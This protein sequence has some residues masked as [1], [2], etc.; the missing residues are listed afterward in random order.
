MTEE[1][2]PV[3][4]IVEP[5]E[6]KEE[7]QFTE[8]EQRAL[9]MGWKP[10]ESF[11]GE[12]DDFID[13]KEFVRRKP[14]FDKIENQNRQVKLLNRAIN[15]L[16]EHYTKVNQASYERALADLKTQRKEAI[17]NGDGEAFGEIDDKIK[18]AEAQKAEL[19]QL[20]QP[21]PEAQDA[22]EFASWKARNTWYANIKYMRA[23]ADELG[24]D[25]HRRGLSPQDVLSEVEKAV[26]NE[27]PD[28]F[29]NPNKASAVSVENSRNVSTKTKDTFELTE[30]ERKIMND[31]VRTK[32]MTKEEYIQGL[33]DV[34]GL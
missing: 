18:A 17:V 27:F 12:E 25:L 3:E 2:K 30:L 21:V 5:V 8:L 20:N 33:K 6:K 11:T 19:E 23:F 7:V 32:T 24:N 26:R 29:R 14:L 10:K 31:F 9:D 15:E 28:K 4:T 34:R 16:K 1:V 22:P 13:A